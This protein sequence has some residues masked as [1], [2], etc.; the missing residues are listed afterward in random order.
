[1]QTTFESRMSGAHEKKGK[2]L[3]AKKSDCMNECA[4]KRNKSPE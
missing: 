2:T 1:M 4:Q 3:R